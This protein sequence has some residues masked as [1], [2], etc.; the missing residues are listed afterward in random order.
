MS[1]S[2]TLGLTGDVMLGRLVNR[3]QKRTER[4]V[5]H[6]W[7]SLLDELKRLD[8][9]LI[10]LEC[11][12]SKRGEKWTKTY[13]PF[14]FRADPEWAVPALKKAG[15]EWANLANNHLMDYGEVALL[16]TLDNLSE[17]GI[18]HSGAG[19]D[20]KDAFQP[21]FVSVDGLDIGFLSLTDNTPEYSAG[22][23]CPGIAHA[24]ID[25]GDDET[26]SRVDQTLSEIHERNPDLVVASLHW[27]PNMREAPSDEFQDF[28]HWLV[29][30]GVDLIHGHSAHIFQG[31][32]VYDG[33]LV[34][35]DTGDFV[36]DYKVDEELRNDRSFLF[37][38]KVNGGEI[39]ELR[40]LPTEIYDFAVH[41][42]DGH[43]AEWSRSR[44]RRLS[45]AFG[46][47]FTQDG[48]E[49]VLSVD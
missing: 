28:A 23:N 12:L 33:S 36:D 17:V 11:C 9:L 49:L 15:V 42:A 14:H 46:T 8:G 21:A 48:E 47:Q 6:V 38:I 1:D 16:D 44:M 2:A 39:N 18:D 4:G 41:E 20:I 31:V 25:K 10:N 3:K 45:E 22:P 13:R 27:G 40:L 35:Y 5:E 19:E 43:A 34:L 30:K 7:G 37:K 32:E 26:R 29:E 24:E